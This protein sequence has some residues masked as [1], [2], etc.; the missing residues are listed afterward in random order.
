[1]RST[2]P[3]SSASHIAAAVGDRR[4]AQAVLLQVLAQ[5]AADLRV[6]VDDQD[7]VGRVHGGI[8]RWLARAGQEKGN[9]VCQTRGFVAVRYQKVSP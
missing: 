8:L 6:V 3:A 9:A 4:G 7:V 2:R 1:M 5:Q